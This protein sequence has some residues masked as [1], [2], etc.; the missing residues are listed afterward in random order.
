MRRRGPY[1]WEGSGRARKEKVADKR[2]DPNWGGLGAPLTHLVN[3]ERMRRK[4]VLRLLDDVEVGEAR[5]HHQHV[6]AFLHVSLLKGIPPL[7]FPTT[8]TGL[9]RVVKGD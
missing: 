1:P 4:T 2:G 6:G 7:S 3:E 5:L 8:R 9:D